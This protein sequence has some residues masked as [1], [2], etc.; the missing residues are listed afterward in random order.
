MSEGQAIWNTAWSQYSGQDVYWAIDPTRPHMRWHVS[1][2]FANYPGSVQGQVLS[3]HGWYWYTGDDSG[4]KFSSMVGP[5]SSD[6][7]AKADC[8]VANR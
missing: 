1:Y 2:N 5:F 7:A 6:A 8:E 3:A 4:N